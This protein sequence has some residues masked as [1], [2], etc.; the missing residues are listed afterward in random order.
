MNILR[1]LF[2]F[3]MVL[4]I[5]GGS[6]FYIARRIYQ[7]LNYLFPYLNTWIYSGIYIFFALSMFLGFLPIHNSIRKIF[8]LISGYWFGVF[9]YL[10]LFLLAADLI[11]L[12]GRITAIIPGP[13]LTG[14]NF[15]KGIFA[16][17]CTIIVIGYGI[18]NTNKINLVSYDIKMN[19]K[20]L[21]REMKIVLISDTHLGAVNSEKNLAGIVQ[22]INNSK[23][24]IVCIAGDFFNDDINNIQ[25]PSGAMALFRSIE[26]KYGV[27]ACLGNHDGGKTFNEMLTFLE[28]CNIKHLNDESVIIDEKVILTGRIDSSPIGGI[29]GLKR[30]ETDAVIAPLNTKMPVVVMDHSPSN[31]GQYGGGVDLIL[32]GHTHKGQLFP[33]NL[34]TGAIFT[35]D[36]GHYQK[37]KTSPHVVVTSGAS[38]W[39]PPLRVCTNNEIAVIVLH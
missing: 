26:T 10:F 39:G 7:T 22:G 30:K 21:D 11:V 36:Y 38:T 23:P 33:G 5:Y 3:T 13:L 2:A 12:L 9:I 16:V 29:G 19:G 28:Q 31:I 25:N 32:C 34:I 24:D 1:V 27:Y 15:Y 14:M 18:F 37:D 20:T 35:V 17:L 8:T 4:G 6:N